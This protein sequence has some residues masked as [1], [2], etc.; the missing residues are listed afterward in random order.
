MRNEK[1][2]RRFFYFFVERQKV[3]HPTGVQRYNKN[4]T[5]ALEGVAQQ[6]L[7]IIL[8]KLATRVS[9]HRLTVSPTHQLFCLH[10]IPISLNQFNKAVNSLVFGNIF[11]DAGLTFV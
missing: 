10:P 9:T 3:A 7:P 8:V 1:G 11:F 5:Q 4:N 2:E 6:D